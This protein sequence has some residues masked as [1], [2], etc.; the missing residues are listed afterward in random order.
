[1][2]IEMV[3]LRSGHDRRSGVVGAGDGTSDDIATARDVDGAQAVLDAAGITCPTGRMGEGVWDERGV[4]YKLPR[5][6]ISDP[7]N[8]QPDTAE[9]AAAVADDEEIM[10]EENDEDD[11]GKE[12]LSDGEIDAAM[13]P[14]PA[15]MTAEKDDNGKQIRVRA[16]RSDGGR[17]VV[18]EV[19]ESVTVK[20]L[21]KRI[22]EQADV[23]APNESNIQTITSL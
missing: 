11:E 9:T 23:S 16:R 6:V 7:V 12:G 3:G 19:E 20:T 17:D 2:S 22:G 14:L 5:W 13:A 10:A 21:L 4:L 18:V 15:S 8:V 1:M